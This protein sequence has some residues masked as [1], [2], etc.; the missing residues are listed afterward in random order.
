MLDHSS[1]AGSGSTIKGWVGGGFLGDLA[2][3]WVRAWAGL[4]GWGSVIHQMGRVIVKSGVSMYWAWDCMP[5]SRRDSLAEPFL[6]SLGGSEF[7]LE[8]G[9]SLLPGFKGR[10]QASCREWR[11]RFGNCNEIWVLS[12]ASNRLCQFLL[13][14]RFCCVGIRAQLK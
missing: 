1:P 7:V 12:P 13:R 9:D 14:F 11:L 2:L 6:L 5:V 3:V 10:F 8:E 4:H